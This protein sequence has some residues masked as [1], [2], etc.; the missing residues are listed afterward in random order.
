MLID[1]HCHV[2]RIGQNDHEWPASDLPAIHRDF[3][4]TDLARAGAGVGL[5]GAVL[6]QSQPRERDTEWLLEIAAE[7][8][9]ALVSSAGPIS[10]R[11][12]RPNGSPGWRLTPV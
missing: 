10:P 12:T 8:L 5:T 1:A 7:D 3:D 4:L 11:L 2:W 9:L 6:V